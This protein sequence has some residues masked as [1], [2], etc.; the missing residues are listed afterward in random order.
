[1]IGII[2]TISGIRKPLLLLLKPT[3]Q[4]FGHGNLHPIAGCRPCRPCR[5]DRKP[6]K[7]GEKT[8]GRSGETIGKRWENMGKQLEHIGNMGKTIGQILEADAESMEICSLSP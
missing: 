3:N 8:I 7:N 4:Y 6:V 5:G 2:T 1:M